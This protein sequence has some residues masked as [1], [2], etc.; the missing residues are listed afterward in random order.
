MRKETSF[1]RFFEK[2]RISTQKLE[3]DDPKLSTKTKVSSNYEERNASVEFA[4]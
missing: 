3:I 4:S 2:V 1:H